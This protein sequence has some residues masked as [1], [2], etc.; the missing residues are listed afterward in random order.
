MNF[1]EDIGI[2]GHLVISKRYAD[3]EE[4]VVL[5]DSNIIV[6]GMGVSLSYFFTAS[7]SESVLDHQI[8]KFQVGVSGP[9]AGGVTSAINELSGSLTSI[10]EYGTGTNLLITTDNQLV[11]GNTVADQIFANIPASKMTRIGDSSVRYTL[12]L[13]E[14]ACNDLQRAS[15]DAPI[16]EVGLFTNNPTGAGKDT[17]LLVAY[18]TFSDIYK[19]ADFSLI[20]RWTINW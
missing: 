2:T 16:N 17:A 3:G 13:D 4:E 5:D 8:G 1:I 19:T 20:F 12:V 15:V 14:E 9:P 7:G 11:N 6:S 10:D 18:R